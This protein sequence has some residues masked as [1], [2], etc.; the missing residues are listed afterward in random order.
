MSGVPFCS[1]DVGGFDYAPEAFDEK[2]LE[3]YPR[4]PEVYIRWLQFGVFSSHIRAHGKQSREPWA[5]GSFAEEIA[6]RYLKLR[7]RLLPYIYSEA[8]RSSRSGLPMARPMVLAYQSD[9]NTRGLDLQ[10]MFGESFL[11]APIVT[12]LNR[13]SVYLPQGEWVDYWTKDVVAGGRWIE[14]EAALDRLPLWVRGGAV[15][16]M[17]P[18]MAYVDEKL[19]D[20][21][22]LELYFPQNVGEF[23]VFDE[24]GPDIPVRYAQERDRLHLEVGRAPGLVEVTVY[25]RSIDSAS[26]GDRSI[27]LGEHLGSQTVRFDGTRPAGLVFLLSE[28]D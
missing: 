22:T 17:G 14:V 2:A 1:H 15:I 3:G 11:V 23:V 10:Y 20:P 6:R 9:P 16:P 25:G 4:D 5:Y 19:L 24:E 18:E 12:P 8:A 7:Y 21:L 13:R 28:G 26:R 27:A